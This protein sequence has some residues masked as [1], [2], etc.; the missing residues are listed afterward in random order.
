MPLGLAPGRRRVGRKAPPEPGNKP[1]V[2]SSR[3]R[4]CGDRRRPGRPISPRINPGRPR[5]C[6]LEESSHVR[7]R[8]GVVLL[9]SRL[10]DHALP[11]RSTPTR[12]CSSSTSPRSGI[13]TGSSRSRSARSPRAATSS[14]CRSVPIRWSSSAAPTGR[15]APSTTPAGTAAAAS[16]PRSREPAPQCRREAR[17]HRTPI[18]RGALWSWILVRFCHQLE[19]LENA[20]A[21]SSLRYVRRRRGRPSPMGHRWDRRTMASR[22]RR[23]PRGPDE[24]PAA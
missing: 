20:P 5:V 9:Q 11:A 19:G 21:N 6:D 16:A 2:T 1:C 4:W 24:T 10:P 7:R 13:A 12:R 8:D 17:R 3:E 18:A 23:K 14:P 15:S 22:P